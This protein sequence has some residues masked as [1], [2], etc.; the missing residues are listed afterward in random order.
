MMRIA[1]EFGFTPA[2]GSGTSTRSKSE[3]TLLDLLDA[4]EKEDRQKSL[5][6]QIDRTKAIKLPTACACCSQM[7]Q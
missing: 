1:S 7:E 5:M 3:R 2:S 6:G 4:S